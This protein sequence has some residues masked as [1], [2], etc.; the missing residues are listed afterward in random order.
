MTPS[1]TFTTLDWCVVAAYFLL[2]LSIGAYFSRG[3][4]NDRGFFLADPLDLPIGSHRVLALLQIFS[5]LL[6]D[7]I[8]ILPIPIN[9]CAVF[10]RIAHQI[11]NP[12]VLFIGL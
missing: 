3:Q 12:A 2:V 4:K 10:F 9:L 8:N 7:F 5:Y 11:D 6:F 1:T